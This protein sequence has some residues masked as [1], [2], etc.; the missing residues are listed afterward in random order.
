[1]SLPSEPAIQPKSKG[2][3]ARRLMVGAAFAATFVAGG[4]AFSVAPALAEMAGGPPAAMGG[5][6]AMM[7]EMMMHHVDRVL[8]LIGATPDQKTKI[9]TI[10][11]TTMQSAGA[12]HHQM[13]DSHDQL[14][15][16][17]TAP[18]IDRA[19]IEQARVAQIAAL[20]QS[21][22]T[23]LNGLADAAEVL[24]PDQRAKVALLLAAREG[25]EHH[26]MGHHGGGMEHHDGDHHDGDGGDH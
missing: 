16:L 25:H 5:D 7:R 11:T 20:D 18:T 12:M 9:D 1:M 4:V 26:G 6:H 23:V 2:G 15:T 19:A 3:W 14:R 21:S 22:K 24:T 17:L 8:D 13:R 10:L